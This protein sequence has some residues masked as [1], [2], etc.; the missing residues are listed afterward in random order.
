MVDKWSF[1]FG[2]IYILIMLAG[3]ICGICYLLFRASQT[4]ELQLLAVTLIVFCTAH[5][6]YQ[7]TKAI[8]II[9]LI[10]EEEDNE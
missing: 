4:L 2:I 9:K 3:A 8:I 5:L 6:T 1:L 10:K 7:I